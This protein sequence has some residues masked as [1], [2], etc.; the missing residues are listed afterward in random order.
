VIEALDA[1]RAGGL[2][3][4][5]E[6]WSGVAPAPAPGPGAPPA[7]REGRRAELTSALA[8]GGPHLVETP[9]DLGL[10][11]VLEAVAGPVSAW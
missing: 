9:V 5:V 8:A 1:A 10:T 7:S 11:S 2:P 6:L 4:V 3:L